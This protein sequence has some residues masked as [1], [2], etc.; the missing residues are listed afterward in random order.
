MRNG[1]TTG[2]LDALDFALLDDLLIEL[3]ERVA[4]AEEHPEP[5]F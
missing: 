5:A 2:G 1:E 4:V 3:K